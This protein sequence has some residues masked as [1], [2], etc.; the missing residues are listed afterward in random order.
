M[1]LLDKDGL[2]HLIDTIKG[3]FE[4]ISTEMANVKK[5]VSDGKKSVADAI[6]AKGQT[7]A[8]DATFATMATNIGKIQ[9]G[10][11][12]SGTLT[13]S[14][15]TSGTDC[16]NYATVKT[17]GL[18]VIPTATLTLTDVATNKDCL[19][20]A[21]VTTSGLVKP[22]TTKAGGTYSLGTS[23]QT[24]SAG[25]YFSAN[26][27][28]KG[29]TSGT[30]TL[31]D[32][33]SGTNCTNYS[34]VKTSGLM[35]TPT[36]TLTKSYTTNGTETVDCTNYAKVSITRNVDT[37]SSLTPVYLGQVSVSKTDSAGD[38]ISNTITIGSEYKY[39]LMSYSNYRITGSS[40]SGSFSSYGTY[41]NGN[42]QQYGTNATFFDNLYF[43]I[44]T[45][46]KPGQ[47]NTLAIYFVNNGSAG[48]GE[49]NA[50]F[51]GFK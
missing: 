12:P 25:T 49:A 5:S 40:S 27:T 11:T 47:T 48:Y 29:A 19:N 28:I 50:K 16:T 21:K 31:S 20:Y 24:I 6:T 1:N 32:V 42:K 37:T 22:T 39:L 10:I 34:S 15:V 30:L 45:G 51:Y 36:A 44:L 3:F 17:S 8:A 43:G 23:D 33:T 7:T 35:K 2:Q 18:M 14:N 13:L 38:R 9:T 41:F 46:I 26:A 4:G